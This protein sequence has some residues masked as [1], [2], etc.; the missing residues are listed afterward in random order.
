MP[1]TPATT[2]SL[3]C[4]RANCA[5]TWSGTDLTK[6]VGWVATYGTWQVGTPQP[7]GIE[8]FCPSHT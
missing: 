7:M 6:A 2:Y 5:N 8:V 3:T 1:I 4:D